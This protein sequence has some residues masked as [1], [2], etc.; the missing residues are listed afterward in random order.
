MS[1][2]SPSIE[3]LELSPDLLGVGARLLA[4]HMAGWSAQPVA[5]CEQALRRLLDFPGAH[6]VLARRSGQYCGFAALH[7]GFSKT[8]GLP[9]LRIQDLFVSPEQRRQGVARA[10]LGYAVDQAHARSANRLQ[11]ETGTGNMA[12]RSLYES[13]EFERFP[14]KEIYMLFLQARS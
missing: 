3:M 2:G 12:A 13:F 5:Q 11:L 8:K 4:A 14:H 10:L 9:I 7:W 6:F 1:E